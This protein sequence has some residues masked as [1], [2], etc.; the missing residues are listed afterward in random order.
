MHNGDRLRR[1]SSEGAFPPHGRIA[2]RDARQEHTVPG[3][4]RKQTGRKS[5]E[6]LGKVDHYYTVCEDNVASP[7]A[8]PRT[9]LIDQGE[10]Q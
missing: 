5:R 7:L 6:R 2:Y 9:P 8:E 10:C 1:T 3:G 4:T